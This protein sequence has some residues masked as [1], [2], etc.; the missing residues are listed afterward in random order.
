MTF[1]KLKEMEMTKEINNSSL[2]LQSAAVA[3]AENIMLRCFV[4]LAN[5]LAYPVLKKIVGSVFRSMKYS[6]I[7]GQIPVGYSYKFTHFGRTI[8][9][10]DQHD[11]HKHAQL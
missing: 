9:V 8:F 1:S 3:A 10:L 4:C 2:F 5:V 6:L 11:V 7:I